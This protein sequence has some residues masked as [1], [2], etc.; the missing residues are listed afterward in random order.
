[1]LSEAPFPSPLAPADIALSSTG[2]KLYVS[3]REKA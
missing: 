3:V 1:M 2:P